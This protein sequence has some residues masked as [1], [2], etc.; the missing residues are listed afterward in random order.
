MGPGH[1]VDISYFLQSDVLDPNPSRRCQHG[2]TTAW[3][4]LFCAVDG[5]GVSWRPSFCGPP[6]LQVDVDVGTFTLTCHVTSLAFGADKKVMT[7]VEDLLRTWTEE[8]LRIDEHRRQ[9]DRSNH[10]SIDLSGSYSQ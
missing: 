1:R 8:M 9:K 10:R 5:R 7:S 2:V 6:G 4:V 3:V